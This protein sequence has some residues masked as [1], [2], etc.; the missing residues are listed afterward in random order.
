MGLFSG[1]SDMLFGKDK[2]MSASN[3]YFEKSE[4][5]MKQY[6]QPFVDYGWGFSPS[7]QSNYN[8]LVN[9]PAAML[10]MFMSGYEPSKA[11]QMQ[12]DRMGQ[13]AANSAAAGGFR[14]APLEQATQQEITQGLLSQDMQKY[15]SNVLGLYGTGLQGQQGMFNTGFN[16]SSGLSSDLANLYGSQGSMAY[17]NAMQQRAA[18]QG[19]FGSLLGAGAGLGMAAL[20]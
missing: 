5:A 11:Y 1:M 9:D 18:A 16:A 2:S 6:M 7:L 13:A 17:N 14:G 20:M 12:Q 15:L 8:N 3:P 19:L 4:A 10:E